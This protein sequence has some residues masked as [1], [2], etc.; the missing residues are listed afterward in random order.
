VDT[1]NQTTL[2]STRAGRGAHTERPGVTLTVLWHPKPARIGVMVQL[3]FKR[4][5]AIDLCRTAPV[6]EDGEP[7]SDPYVSRTPV[8]LVP[9]RDGAVSLWPG[10]S[11]L[12]FTLDG[13]PAQG[14]EVLSAER[15]RRGVVVGL[16]RGSVVLVEGG[17]R[18]RH[19]DPLG[20][21]GCSAGLDAV[22]RQIEST[23]RREGSVL[24][25]GASG[26]GKELVSRAVHDLS[27]RRNRPY[28]AVNMAAL[29]EGTA[30]SQLF[31]H[32]RGA[33]TG[34][35]RDSQ[36]FFGQAH[37]GTLF[38]D[39]V[40]ACPLPIQSQL[41]RAL[42][43]G[44]VQ[45]VGGQVRSVDVRVVAATD[46]DLPIAVEE[47]RFLA[48]LYYRLAH[49]KVQIPRLSDRLA[50][51]AVQ[52]V[53]FV[54]LAWRELGHDEVLQQSPP[55]YA[56]EVAEALLAHP[57]PG[58]TRELRSLAMALTDQGSD[59]P[60]GPPVLSTAPAPARRTVSKEALMTP[61]PAPTTRRG[62]RGVDDAQL[63]EVLQAHAYSVGPTAKALGMG[64]QTLRRRIKKLGLPSPNDL[65]VPTIRAALDASSTV[66]DAAQ[67]LRVSPHGLALRMT[68]LKMS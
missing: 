32:S 45:P 68:Q 7:L 52:A 53:H 49:Q 57:W 3:A 48:P 46:E 20:L 56:R 63:L 38:L 33:F 58:N 64:A 36:G 28:V 62:S 35:A 61:V 22:R 47:G 12:Y 39:E 29:S 5:A 40:G 4:G 18:A 43:S 23:A 1:L 10:R 2:D 17:L 27:S 37:G 67:A 19:P 42:E 6:F 25:L 15:L 24:V 65:D 41:L 8:Q 21:V 34:A 51:V 60:C 14:G 50:D 26:T 59:M 54:R 16:G 44:E 13:Q 66:A 31:G 30:P 9:E 11:G 55:W